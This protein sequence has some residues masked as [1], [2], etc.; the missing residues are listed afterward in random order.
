MPG[1]GSSE[2]APKRPS[3]QLEAWNAEDLTQ[4]V[5]TEITDGDPRTIPCTT[6]GGDATLP[7]DGSPPGDRRTSFSLHPSPGSKE[8]RFQLIRQHA[9][10]GIGQVWLARD[11][12]LQRDV[13]VKEIQPQYADSENQRA[14]VRA[15]GGDHRQS[16]TSGDRSG[17]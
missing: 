10:G 11:A 17:V 9:Q 6:L 4:D 3:P 8:Q 15:R 1:V 5:L 16:R 14:Q 7:L 13:A 2:D 12:E